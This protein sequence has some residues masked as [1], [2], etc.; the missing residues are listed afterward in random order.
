M[1]SSQFNVSVSTKRLERSGESST[2]DGLWKIDL[3]LPY[4]KHRIHNVI[5][6]SVIFGST[7]VSCFNILDCALVTTK[8]SSFKQSVLLGLTNSF[9]SNISKCGGIWLWT[10]TTT[11]PFAKSER[12]FTCTKGIGIISS[13]IPLTKQNYSKPNNCIYANSL[14]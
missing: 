1:I 6:M 5:K 14:R 9:S 11:L 10:P 8:M 12:R 4:I 13:V 7:C 3:L 2:R